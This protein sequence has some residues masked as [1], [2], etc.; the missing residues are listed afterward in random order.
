MIEVSTLIG[1]V[2]I[3]R[4]VPDRLS[5]LPVAVMSISPP[6]A[7]AAIAAPICVN[8]RFADMEMLRLT[9]PN[10]A[11][12]IPA[13]L[14]VTVT[15]DVSMEMSPPR[16]D[17]TKAPSPADPDTS[18]VAFMSTDPVPYVLTSIPLAPAT[19]ATLTE[20]LAS[21]RSNFLPA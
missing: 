7:V 20:T 18:P 19:L 12:E 10:M 3:L 16:H 8:T 17:K 11:A 14:P 5:T 13:S 21:L 9:M 15:L 2:L 4:P 6:K 1:P